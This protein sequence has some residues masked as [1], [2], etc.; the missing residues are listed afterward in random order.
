MIFGTGFGIGFDL[1]FGGKESKSNQN[2]DLG[3]Y[4]TRTKFKI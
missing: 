4:G 1:F 3:F 2:H